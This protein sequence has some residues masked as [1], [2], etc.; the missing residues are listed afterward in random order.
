MVMDSGD[1]CDMGYS[2]LWPPMRIGDI[3]ICCQVVGGGT[4]RPGLT[5]YNGLWRPGHEHPTVRMRAEHT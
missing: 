2:L 1:Y 5:T 3:H 4:V